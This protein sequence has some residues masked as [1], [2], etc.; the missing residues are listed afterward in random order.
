MRHWFRFSVILVSLSCTALLSSADEVKL[1]INDKIQLVVFGEP[2]LSTQVNIDSS[3]SVQFPLV[4][5]LYVVDKTTGQV[6]SEV[7]ARLEADYIR[8]A[9]VT[10]S[11]IAEFIDP[12]KMIEERIKMERKIME[13]REAREAER[14]RARPKVAAMPVEEEVTIST[15]TVMGEVA[16]P[17][18]VKFEGTT[19]DILT[20]V[21]QVRTTPLANVKKVTVRRVGEDGGIFTVNLAELQSSTEQFFVRSGDTITVPK[22]LF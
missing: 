13:A 21:A 22:R 5:S 11:V 17:G 14:E 8:D 18:M 15:V 3:G 10:V 19:A 16:T 2:S 9:N 6:A 1:K 7:E 12:E 20:V 4:G